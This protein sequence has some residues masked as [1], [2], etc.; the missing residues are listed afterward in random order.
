MHINL[1]CFCIY[2]YINAEFRQIDEKPLESET[3][4]SFAHTNAQVW[5][6]KA[7]S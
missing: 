7:I 4:G 1:C 3:V 6:S 5:S 2:D